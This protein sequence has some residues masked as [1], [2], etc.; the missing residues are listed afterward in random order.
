MPRKF[1]PQVSEVVRGLES[2]RIDFGWT[3]PAKQ[4]DPALREVPIRASLRFVG[5]DGKEHTAFVDFA[6]PVAGQEASLDAK[7]AK[8][9]E[10]AEQLLNLAH[11]VPFADAVDGSVEHVEDEPSAASMGEE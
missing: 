10:L 8:F 6:P 1:T 5:T 3:P 11:K 4:G 2:V 7:T 9:V